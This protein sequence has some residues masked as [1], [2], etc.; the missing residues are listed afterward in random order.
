LLTSPR[1]TYEPPGRAAGG[2][3]AAGRGSALLLEKIVRLSL[4][5]G[6]ID[7]ASHEPHS[8]ERLH[9]ELVPVVRDLLQDTLAFFDSILAT[10]DSGDGEE[11]ADS[12]GGAII[13]EDRPSGER[14][15]DLAFMARLELRQKTAN[16]LGLPAAADS[17]RIIAAAGSCLRQIQKALAALEAA[18]SHAEGV[19]PVLGSSDELALG[20][21][22]RR[23]YAGFRRQL[24]EVGRLPGISDRLQGAATHIA[25]LFDLA[26]YRDLRINDR[27]QLRRLLERILRWGGPT[28]DREGG[29]RIWGDLSA[30]AGLLAEISKR[31]ELQEHDAA[32]CQEIRRWLASLPSTAAEIPGDLRAL[33]ASLAGRDDELDDRIF[34]AREIDRRTAAAAVQRL[35]PVQSRFTPRPRA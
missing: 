24:R 30:C 10:D 34:S 27:V 9:A 31:Q 4:S 11:T 26:I 33:L 18:I 8:A 32:V 5:A 20:L 7:I 17:W 21:A 23:A 22:A 28:V 15:A 19:T 14:V 13:L 25:D 3:D 35:L 2:W 29:E 12:S 1:S 6:S 16:L